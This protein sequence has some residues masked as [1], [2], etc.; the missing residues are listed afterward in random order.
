MTWE[1][2]WLPLLI[3]LAKCVFAVAF[4]MQIVP[5]LIWGE[6]KGA[7]YIQDRPGPNRAYIGQIGRAHV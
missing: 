7:A 1:D 6:R 4:V 5:L 3:V 2:F